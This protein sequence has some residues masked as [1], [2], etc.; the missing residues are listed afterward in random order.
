[1]RNYFSGEDIMKAKKGI[2]CIAL[3][4]LL[5]AGIPAWAEGAEDAS[6]VMRSWQ[7]VFRLTETMEHDETAFTEGLSVYNGDLYESTGLNDHSRIVRYNGTSVREKIAEKEFAEAIFA[8]GS[9]VLDGTLYLLTWQNG[10]AVC[11]DPETL[12]FTGT[13]EYPRAGWGLTA[14]GESLIAGDGTDCLYFMD[15]HLK[16]TKE[17]YVRCG[18]EKLT[19]INELE[20][21]GEYI[22]ANVWPENYIAVI[23][24]ETGKVLMKVDFS[25]LL[26]ENAEGDNVLNGIAFDGE[27]YYFTGKNWPVMYKMERLQTEKQS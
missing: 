21:D 22:W 2:V 7:E 17:L 8:E 6:P 12:E 18:E 15:S 11:F 5:C 9:A 27:Y 14:D 19:N 23:D 25:E 10:L 4:L 13:I 3:V 16:T 20:Y 26:P 24:P 1:M